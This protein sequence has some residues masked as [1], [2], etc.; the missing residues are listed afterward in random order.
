MLQARATC[1]DLYAEALRIQAGRPTLPLSSCTAAAGSRQPSAGTDSKLLM[2]ASTDP[3]SVLDRQSASSNGSEDC[4]TAGFSPR[5]SLDSD[6][7]DDC[8][9]SSPFAAAASCG[10]S[11][12]SSGGSG[13]TAA[14]AVVASSAAGPASFPLPLHRLLSAASM[15]SAASGCLDG[16]CPAL[17]AS[18]ASAPCAASS[19]GQAERSVI[20]GISLIEHSSLLASSNHLLAGCPSWLLVAAAAVLA[21]LAALLRSLEAAVRAELRAAEAWAARLAAAAQPE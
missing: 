2:G 17:A 21:L 14:A 15:L 19:F 10:S 18:P 12:G 5:S 11:A 6:S 1:Q 3:T 7:C 9:S 8:A 16:C 13:R 4:S 20:S